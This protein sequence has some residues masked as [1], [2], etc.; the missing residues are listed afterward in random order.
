M[1]IQSFRGAPRGISAALEETELLTD[2]PK[3][4]DIEQKEPVRSHKFC[5]QKS[6]RRRRTREYNAVYRSVGVGLSWNTLI[7]RFDILN[8]ASVDP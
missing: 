4:K 2:E 1:G 6:G 5:A 8:E 3:L 7:E